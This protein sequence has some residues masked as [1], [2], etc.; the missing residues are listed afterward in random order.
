MEKLMGGGIPSKNLELSI[1]VPVYNVEK[2]IGECLDSILKIKNINYE[3][4]VIND[5]SPDNSQKI[6]DEY[7]KKDARVKS[8]IKEN[9]GISS[10]RNYGIKKAQGE[11]IWFV[12]SDDLVVASE[13]EKFFSYQKNDKQDVFFGEYIEFKDDNLPKK[14]ELEIKIYD[15]FNVL[16]EEF[17]KKLQ[18]VWRGIYKLEFLKKE[19]IF[20]KENLKIGEDLLF[21]QIV[22][23]KTIKIKYINIS[24]YYYRRNR[25]GSI[26]TD[27]Y[28]DRIKEHYEIAKLLAINVKNKNIFKVL[29]KFPIEFYEIF[30]AQI[31][32]RDLEVEKELW[33]IDGI[34]FFKLKRRFKIFKKTHIYHKYKIK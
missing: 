3:V 34:Y 10:A 26:L 21:N 14:M 11:Y 22:M 2:Y 27:F 28:K 20:F 18:T 19:N 12:D 29:K 15:K 1:I 7:C 13:F 33:K 32:E 5:G 25:K 6:I 9:G 30:L 16:F 8:F 31:T 4:L 24:F 17:K 23:S